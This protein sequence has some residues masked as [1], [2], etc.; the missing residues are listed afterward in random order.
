M[1]KFYQRWQFWFYLVVVILEIVE[2][3]YVSPFN[4]SDWQS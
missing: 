2:V 4:M 3:T 1:R